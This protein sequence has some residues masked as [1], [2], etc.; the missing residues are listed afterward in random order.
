MYCLN[1]HSDT[2]NICTEV[3]KVNEIDQW[4]R[5][6]VARK[7]SNKSVSAR[8]WGICGVYILPWLEFGVP[9][10]AVPWDISITIVII[11]QVSF[12]M[13]T[14][15][16]RLTNQTLSYIVFLLR[17]MHTIMQIFSKARLSNQTLLVRSEWIYCNR[18]MIYNLLS[19][20][21]G[22]YN[23]QDVGMK[24]KIVLHW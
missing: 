4:Q 1:L 5:R 10:I 24:V 22:Q 8:V 7:Q 3:I 20:P 16:A 15:K 13:E 6:N 19:A 21:C 18:T 9:K 17:H 11:P 14:S 2:K 12:S 23:I